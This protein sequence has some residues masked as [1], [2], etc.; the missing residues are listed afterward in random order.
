MINSIAMLKR[1]T[2][3]LFSKVLF[4]GSVL[5]LLP[6]LYGQQSNLGLCV[7]CKRYSVMGIIRFL[8][9]QVIYF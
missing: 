5:K 4:A 1:T 2:N 9:E 8:N 7:N 6:P 3:I